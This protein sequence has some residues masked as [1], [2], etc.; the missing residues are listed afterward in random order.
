MPERTARLRRFRPVAGS[1]SSRWSRPMHRGRSRSKKKSI[2]RLLLAAS[3]YAAAAM[4]GTGGAMRSNSIPKGMLAIYERIV[5]LT[6]DVCERQLNS[7]YRDLAL[8]MTGALCRKRPSPLSSGQPRTWAGGIV[9]VLG[10]INFLGDRSFPPYMTTAD[11]CAAFG[12]GES[13]VHAKARAIE[14]TLG[15]GAFDPK[16]ALPSSGLSSAYITATLCTSK[17]PMAAISLA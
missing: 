13:T 11:L 6:D 10:R 9:Y 8:S 15:T 16:W 2:V 4:V 7:E 12:V 3:Y 5:G 1:P 14:K 17:P